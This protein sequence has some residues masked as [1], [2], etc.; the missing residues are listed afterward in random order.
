MPAPA[1]GASVSPLSI[2]F[3]PEAGVRWTSAGRRISLVLNAHHGLRRAEAGGTDLFCESRVTTGADTVSPGSLVVTPVDVRRVLPG[4][5]EERWL[6]ALDLPLFFWELESAAGGPVKLEGALA[7][8][9]ASAAWSHGGEARDAGL[10]FENAGGKVLVVNS[11]LRGA[12]LL[13]LPSAGPQRIAATAPGHLRLAIIAAEDAADLHRTL[14]LLARRG[15]AGLRA[16]RAQHARLIQEYGTTLSTPVPAFDE[17]FEWAKLRADEMAAPSSAPDTVPDFDTVLS[18]PTESA[19]ADPAGFIR[20][21]A[22]RL[23]GAEPDAEHLALTLTPRLPG[24][25]ERMTISRLRVGSAALDCALSRRAGQI[26]VR[27]RRRTGPV[28]SV[29]LALSGITTTGLAMDDIPLGGQEARFEAAGEHEIV[30][31]LPE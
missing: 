4:G 25:W 9:W 15:F 31:D 22:K 3:P 20:S 26:T 8:G 12:T 19:I 23:W 13:R 17:A 11:D 1:G 2:T 18:S 30:F 10:R 21:A 24:G 7:D 27:V 28:V 29:T 14:D 16:Q 5:L 6:T